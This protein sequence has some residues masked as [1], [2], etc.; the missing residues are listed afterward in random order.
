MQSASLHIAPTQPKA[1]LARRA[2]VWVRN[3]AELVARI[4]GIPLA[5]LVGHLIFTASGRQET[6]ADA[7]FIPLLYA[8][9]F[10]QGNFFI[11][12][13]LRRRYPA[14]EQT[15]KRISISIA[16]CLAFTVVASAIL[17]TTICTIATCNLPTASNLFSSMLIHIGLTT[18][19]ATLYESVY[20][21][22][23]WKK[24]LIEKG[25]LEQNQLQAQ[26]AH[27]RQQINPHFLFN[28]FNLL[29]AVIEENPPMAAQMVQELARLDRKS[30][31]LNSSH[32]D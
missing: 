24:S 13:R 11:L 15:S 14:L 3:H 22:N 5:G 21:F 7:T 25:A 18:F 4:I 30:T 2:K 8:F 9:V 29:T 27:L 16:V 23:Q 20:F 10:W 32:V 31:R 6:G 28:N 19:I 26:L 17:E 12:L 1:S